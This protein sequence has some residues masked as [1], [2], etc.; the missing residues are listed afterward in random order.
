M[1]GVQCYLSLEL[2]HKYV[3]SY[4]T[5]YHITALSCLLS[6]RNCNHG[7]NIRI[8]YKYVCPNTFRPLNFRLALSPS[9]YHL[10]AKVCENHNAY[11]LELTIDRHLAP[12]SPTKLH[13]NF[14]VHNF[15]LLILPSV[16]LGHFF[17]KILVIN[18]HHHGKKA[19]TKSNSYFQSSIE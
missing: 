11:S 2:S 17:G 7:I 10:A 12:L 1:S 14:A 19:H 8:T 9:I 18:K 3:V 6:V 4:T 5:I 16:N 13:K 15:L